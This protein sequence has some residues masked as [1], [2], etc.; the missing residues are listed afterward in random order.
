MGSEQQYT[1]IHPHSCANH[2]VVRASFEQ[3]MVMA[4]VGQLEFSL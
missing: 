3:E 2:M 1:Q 4:H